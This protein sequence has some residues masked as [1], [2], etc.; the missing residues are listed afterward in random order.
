MR[1][2]DLARYDGV[3]AY[4]PR[5]LVWGAV[6]RELRCQRGIAKVQKPMKNIWGNRVP[7][8]IASLP[9][10][11]RVIERLERKKGRYFAMVFQVSRAR[12]RDNSREIDVENIY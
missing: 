2:V 12:V 4:M 7:F 10:F 3:F 9:E 8:M 6:N 11:H 1:A 5:G